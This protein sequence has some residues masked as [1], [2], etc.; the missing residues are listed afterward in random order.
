MYIYI[1]LVYTVHTHIDI[2]IYISN[3]ARRTFGKLSKTVISD[4]FRSLLL[5][6]A[7]TQLMCWMS[8]E[9]IQPFNTASRVPGE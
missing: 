8:T 1:Y 2:Y 6:L 4:S 5:N 7:D 3:S 9:H